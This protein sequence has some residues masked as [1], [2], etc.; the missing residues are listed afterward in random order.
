MLSLIFISFIVLRMPWS[1]CLIHLTKTACKY[2]RIGSRIVLNVRS[3]VRV[4]L[5]CMVIYKHWRGILSIIQSGINNNTGKIGIVRQR[6]MGR[7]K[8]TTTSVARWENPRTSCD[9][10]SGDP[11]KG[12]NQISIYKAFTEYPMS[13]VICQLEKHDW[14]SLE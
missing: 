6:G 13:F 10:R 4:I 12:K 8:T 2:L 1:A 9:S 3:G 14:Y 11:G 5:C 7:S